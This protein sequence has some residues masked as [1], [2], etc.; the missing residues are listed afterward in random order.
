MSKERTLTRS[1]MRRLPLCA[2][3]DLDTQK[4]WPCFLSNTNLDNVGGYGTALSLTD[5]NWLKISRS[6]RR[7]TTR[8]RLALEQSIYMSALNLEIAADEAT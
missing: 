4:L 8:P 2:L 7:M 6:P 5:H 1:V 3:T